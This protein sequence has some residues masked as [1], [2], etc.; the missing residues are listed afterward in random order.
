MIKLI[1][2][3]LKVDVVHG[4]T[5]WCYGPKSLRVAEDGGRYVA[6][7]DPAQ[8]TIVDADESGT[9]RSTT[10][11]YFEVD[12]QTPEGETLADVREQLRGAAHDSKSPRW[13]ISELH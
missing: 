10:G 8:C 4:S 5:T 9:V 2:R 12:G 3:P 1:G 13:A 7:D 6:S 11:I